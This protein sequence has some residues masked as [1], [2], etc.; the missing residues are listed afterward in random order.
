MRSKLTYLLLSLLIFSCE[1]EVD[2]NLDTSLN[3][4]VIDA[5]LTSN[6]PTQHINITRSQSYFDS[7]SPQ[8][9]SGATVTITDLTEPSGPAY[10]FQEQAERYTWQSTDMTPLGVIGHQYQLTVE[11]DG[12]IFT[13]ITTLEDAPPIDSISFRL[14]EENSF[15][16]DMIFG[17]IFATDLVGLNDTYWIK[18]WKN[19]ELLGKPSEINLAYDAAFSSDPDNDGFQFIQPIRDGINPFEEARNGD[20]LSPYQLPLVLTRSGD[21]LRYKDDG[22]FYGIIDGNRILFEL[23]EGIIENNRVPEDLESLPIDDERFVQLPGNEVLVKGDSVYVEIHSISNDAYFFMNQVIIETTREG[24][25]GALFAT[26]LANVS[27]NIVPNNPS[28]SV[29]G[30]FNIATVTSGGARLMDESQV[31]V[32]E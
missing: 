2:P 6:D 9:V 14:E 29:V 16:D 8:K 4:L 19:G 11:L 15:L 20:F 1:S 10:V 28:I 32:V 31:R 25:F 24:G 5:F 18:T 21:T 3:V 23:L 27:T 17:E 12:S 26:P 13:S 22:S 30:F 7:N